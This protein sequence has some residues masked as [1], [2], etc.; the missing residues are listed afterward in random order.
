MVAPFRVPPEMVVALM[1]PMPDSEGD[2]TPT[3]FPVRLMAP[4][5]LVG[6]FTVPVEST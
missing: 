6:I 3:I 4:M 5:V 1:E 2:P